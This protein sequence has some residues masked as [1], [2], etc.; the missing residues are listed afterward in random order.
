MDGN[1]TSK[2]DGFPPGMNSSALTYRDAATHYFQD[3]WHHIRNA[4]KILA[5]ITGASSRT[6]R[7]WIYGESA[8]TGDYMIALMAYDPRFKKA[9]DRL[10]AEHAFDERQKAF[11]ASQIIF[12]ARIADVGRNFDECP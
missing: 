3:V 7:G 6:T 1:N 9:V 8:P 12:D 10:E 4:P 2:S 5:R 11:L